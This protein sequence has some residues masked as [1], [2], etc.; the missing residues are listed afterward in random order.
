MFHLLYAFA[1]S[2]FANVY[3]CSDLY[4]YVNEVQ[5]F[6]VSNYVCIAKNKTALNGLT[7]TVIIQSNK[8]F[9]TRVINGATLTA[10]E[11]RLRR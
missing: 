1:Y 9:K 8:T 7:N 6:N 4:L 5:F 2:L 3:R 11:L 10:P